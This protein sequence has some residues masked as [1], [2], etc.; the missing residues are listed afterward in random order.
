[1]AQV[2]VEMTQLCL[3]AGIEDFEIVFDPE[4]SAEHE[5]NPRRY[6]QVNLAPPRPVFEFAEQICALPY[7]YRLGLYAHEVGHVLDPDPEKTEPGADLAAY[8]FLGI[9]IVYD[10]R[11]PG[12]G[13]Q[14]ALV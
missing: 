13:L 6:A 8:E 9:V 10:C 2:G 3:V 7:P 14:K 4:V 1:M 11:W 12:K 5:R